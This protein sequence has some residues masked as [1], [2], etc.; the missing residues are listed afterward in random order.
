[1]SKTYVNVTDDQA[2]QNYH[3][4][5]LA[6]SAAAN[7]GWVLESAE[8]SNLGGTKNNAGVL[9]VGDDAKNRQ[10]RSI[11]SFDTSSLPNNAVLTSVVLKIK[12]AG[13][14]GLSLLGTH[15][16]LG[17]DIKKGAFGNTILELSDFQRAGAPISTVGSFSEAGGSWYR[18][19]L[20]PANFKYINLTGVTQFRLRFARDDDDDRVMDIDIFYAGD[21]SL[22]KPQLIIEYTVP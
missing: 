11:L 16:D 13:G 10:Y 3:P 20:N 2:D 7:D 6:N 17:A 8:T 21:D 4:S 19:D 18:L 14:S 5:M 9:R 15:G 1:V 22:N 12:R